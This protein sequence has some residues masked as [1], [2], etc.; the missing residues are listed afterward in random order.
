MKKIKV[1]IVDDSKTMREWLSHLLESDPEITVIGKAADP[2][3]ARDLIKKTNPDVLTL[4]IIM[5]KMDG[6]TFLKNLMRLHP[7]PV[8][9][10]SSLTETGSVVALEALS[11]GAIDYF[12]KPSKQE[13]QNPKLYKDN[14]INSIK[15]A[16]R[17]NLRGLFKSTLADRRIEHIVY[18]S[19]ILKKVIIVIGASTGGVE[20]IETIL[21]NLPKTFPPIVIVQHIRPEFSAAFAKR[22]NS[23]LRLNIKEA[24]NNEEIVPGSVYIAPSGQHLIIKKVQKQFFCNFEDTPPVHGLKP[25]IDVLFSSAANSA[26]ENAIGV[27][28]TGMGDD[29]AQGAKEIRQAGGIVIAQDKESS[30]VWG[31]PGAAVKLN[32]ADYITP[33]EEIPETLFRVLDNI[34][35]KNL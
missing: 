22:I 15:N 3:E 7:L 28:L 32:A 27:L 2:Y 9:M 16:A 30:V 8:V 6:I 29:G 24:E 20:A 31:I 12:P 34:A 33:L 23:T 21:C 13:Y 25:S 14:L 18:H 11:L 1:L 26:K 19:T 10:I 4:D 35:H 5:P 17:S